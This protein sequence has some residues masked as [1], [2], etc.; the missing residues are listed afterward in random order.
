MGDPIEQFEYQRLKDIL[1][2]NNVFRLQ[3]WAH[4]RQDC[5]TII[6]MVSGLSHYSCF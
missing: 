3:I 4:K 2:S 6:V 5:F 1:S